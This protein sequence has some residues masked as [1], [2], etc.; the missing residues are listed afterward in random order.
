MLTFRVV[1]L[2][3]LAAGALLLARP[4][5]GSAQSKSL[6]QPPAALCVFDGYDPSLP[7]VWRAGVP[8][9]VYHAEGAWTCVGLENGPRWVRSTELRAVPVDTKPRPTA[10]VGRWPMSNGSVTIRRHSGD[11]L[12]ID[13]HAWW[14]GLPGVSHSGRIGGLVVPS[15]NR[16]HF[17]EDDCVLDLAL[18]GTYIVAMDN[19]H[20]GGANVRF[21]GFWKRKVARSPAR[22]PTWRL[23]NVR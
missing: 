1:T 19:Q 14:L 8:A 18:V 3:L 11:T 6:D 12:R 4:R 16:V 5:P 21:W 7:L 20:C 17:V 2:P 10:W 22:Q 13:G 23:Q 9:V 15:G